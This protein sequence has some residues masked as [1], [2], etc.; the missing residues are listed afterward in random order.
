MHEVTAITTGGTVELRQDD[1]LACVVPA[2]GAIVTRLRV[3]NRELLYM[4]ESTLRDPSKNVRGGIP[5]LFPS[6][7]KLEGDRFSRDGHHGTMKQHGFAREMAWTLDDTGT[8]DAASA[9]LILTSDDRTRAAFPW[10]FKATLD[11]SLRNGCLRMGLVVAN[12]GAEPMP[13]AFGIHPYFRVL[14]KTRA[15]IP[16]S[17]TRAFD[18]VTKQT[19]AFRGFD[20]SA[21][22]VDM[23]LYDHGGTTATLAWGDGS[24]LT[25]RGSSELT[26]WVVW[27]VAGKDFVCLE[28]WTAPGNAL[29]TGE[30]LI[31][32][33]PGAAHDLWLELDCTT[34]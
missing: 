4:D 18:N 17:A 28:P 15:R 7:G 6:P 20:L 26:R 31:V 30:S 21:P 22:E 24:A 3:G 25:I 32:V 11:L 14:D 16:T 13:F 9:R 29:N 34:A 2:R 12:T 8:A 5:L 33:P 1:N 19:V 10:D 23:H 27:T